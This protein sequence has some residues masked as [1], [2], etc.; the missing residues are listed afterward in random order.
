MRL[1]DEGKLNAGSSQ[2]ALDSAAFRE[3]MTAS[4]QARGGV[5]GAMITRLG[6]L[7]L[8]MLRHEQTVLEVMLEDGLL[9][10]YYIEAMRTDRPNHKLADLVKQLAQKNPRARVLEIGAGTGGLTKRI[11]PLLGENDGNCMMAH[12]DYTDIS[13]GFFVEAQELFKPWAGRMQYKKLDIERDPSTQGFEDGSYDIVLASQVLHATKDM[14]H[15]LNNVHRLVKPGGKL[16]M[17]E[18]TRAVDDGPV[19]DGQFIFGLLPGWWLGKCI[20]IV[21]FSFLL[22]DRCTDQT[23]CRR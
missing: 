20:P 1:A 17:V 13:T 9:N 2:W 21:L 22:V 5:D 4:V 19:T 11:L 23:C 12:F 15:T 14:V 16:L 3:E 7:L 6:P 8:P 18:F 10:K